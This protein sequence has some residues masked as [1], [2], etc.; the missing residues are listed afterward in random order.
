MLNKNFRE[1]NSLNYFL[2]EDQEGTSAWLII[3]DDLESWKD[4][5]EHALKM[6]SYPSAGPWRTQEAISNWKFPVIFREFIR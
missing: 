3:W 5:L 1:G 4:L 6:A 2:F